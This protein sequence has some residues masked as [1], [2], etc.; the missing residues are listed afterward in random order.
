MLVAGAGGG[1][2]A[3]S[4]VA[5]QHTVAAPELL[6]T[7]YP[8]RSLVEMLARRGDDVWHDRLAHRA[9]RACL[10]VGP[11]TARCGF[12][13]LDGWDGTFSELFDAAATVSC[14]AAAA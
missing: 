11:V 5:A 1:P 4:E 13:L 10:E 7:A 6:W 2:L 8:A 9:A 3:L 12:G 14:T